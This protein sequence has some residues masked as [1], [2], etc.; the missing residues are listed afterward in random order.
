MSL[1]QKSMLKTS[2]NYFNLGKFALIL[3]LCITIAAFITSCTTSAASNDGASP[4]VPSPLELEDITVTPTVGETSPYSSAVIS[5]EAAVIVVSGITNLADARQQTLTISIV[6]KDTD[7]PAYTVT[8]ESIVISAA[9]LNPEGTN[10]VTNRLESDNSKFVI[11]PADGGEV[12]TYSIEVRLAEYTP[13]PVLLPSFAVEDIRVMLNTPPGEPS[14]YPSFSYTVN[15]ETNFIIISGITNLTDRA[16]TETLTVTIADPESQYTVTPESGITISAMQLNPDGVGMETITLD[17]TSAQQFTLTP[18]TEGGTPVTYTVRLLL[19]MPVSPPP[20]MV[21]DIDFAD[22]RDS[23]YN[24]A[25]ITSIDNNNN[26][27]TIGGITNRDMIMFTETLTLTVSSKYTVTA[28]G[29]N[30]ITGSGNALI[31]PASLF[32]VEGIMSTMTPTNEGLAFAVESADLPSTAVIYYVQLD[33]EALI[34]LRF[35]GGNEGDITTELLLT[36]GVIPPS[37]T[38]IELKECAVFLSSYEVLEGGTKSTTAYTLT[39]MSD[40]AI[41]SYTATTYDDVSLVLSEGSTEIETFTPLT[42][43][44]SAC[45]FP[46][47]TATALS[48]VGTSTDP[49]I[50]DND[51][52]LNVFAASINISNAATDAG[53]PYRTAHYK[54]TADIDL[55][56][57]Q[58]PWSQTSS[59]STNGPGFTPMGTSSISFAGMFDCGNKEIANLYINR[60]TTDDIGLFAHVSGATIQN[61]VLTAVN[62]RGKNNVGGLVGRVDRSTI[63]SSYAIGD[64]AGGGSVGGLVGRV[65][66]STISRSY[67]TGN[68]LIGGSITANAGGLIGRASTSTISYSYATGTVTGDSSVGGLVGR[69]DGSMISHSYATGEVSI[70]MGLL[71]TNAGGLV[72]RASAST[73]SDSYATGNVT[74]NEQVGGLVGWNVTD[75]MSMSTITHSYATGN[76]TG[77]TDTNVGLF[78]GGNGDFVTGGDFAS[79]S[80]GVMASYFNNEA[81]LT[82][83]NTEQTGTNKEAVGSDDPTLTGTP[84]VP[85]LETANVTGQSM[86]ALQSLTATSTGWDGDIWEFTP[87]TQYPRLKTVACANRQYVTPVPTECMGI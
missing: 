12:I 85:T 7:A 25:T 64:V 39:V 8:P 72:G 20:L 45:A 48:G 23:T 70:R 81:T 42:V 56:V 28:R 22:G 58:A 86:T 46:L 3:L 38:T 19:D 18:V 33:L 17:S 43:M 51:R 83:T 49:F 71:A 16:K 27:V 50:I 63:T 54:V 59:E 73:I 10:A 2:K 44:T 41:N 31:L 75:A 26:I 5:I 1:L 29:D 60:E 36:E 15:I 24:D 6:D 66:R 62:V 79:I 52:R 37:S 9:V 68:V 35:P 32:N 82:I 34:Q 77:M 53:Q 55:G 87:T 65:D 4:P 80:V 74:G 11:T 61:C 69:A 76:V 47:T 14:R 40:P 13:P 84:P 21:A 30:T 57:A 78:I 67:A